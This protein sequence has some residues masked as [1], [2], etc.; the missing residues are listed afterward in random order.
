MNLQEL[1]KKRFEDLSSEEIKELA[2][3][4]RREYQ[5]EYMRKYRAKHPD[6]EKEWQNRS[7][8]RRALKRLEKERA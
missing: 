2:K 7:A 6:K 5:R 1:T 4:E 8:A 3:L